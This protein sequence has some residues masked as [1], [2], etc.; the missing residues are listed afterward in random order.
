MPEPIPMPIARGFAGWLV[1]AAALAALM[2]GFVFSLH[3][4][5]RQFEIALLAERQAGLIA[6]L[7][8][9]P[10]SQFPPRL[11]EYRALVAQ[12]SALGSPAHSDELARINRLPTMVD[13]ARREALLATMMAGERAEVAAARAALDH[14]RNRMLLLGGMLTLLALVS[15]GTGLWRL[16]WA[17]RALEREV[18]ARSAQLQ[19][20]DRSRRLFFAKASHELRTPVAAMRSLAEV[21]LSAGGDQAAALHDVVAQAQF[22]SHRIDEMLSLASAQEGRPVLAPAPY[23][24]REIVAGALSAAGPF[25]R[26]VEVELVYDPP[27][28]SVHVRADGRWLGQALLAIIDNGLKISDPGAALEITLIR[29]HAYAI[30]SIADHGPGMGE[31]DLPLIFEAY[32]Q[33]EEGRHRGG[34]GLGLALARWVADQHGGTIRAENRATGGARIVLMLPL[35]EA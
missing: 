34:T 25:A 19:A 10:L 31:A 4:A 23:D 14:S 12:E 33:S 3:S 18:A 11:A 20:V 7:S 24:L 8:G 15:A 5:A 29:D 26:L 35:E 22:L 13:T 1:M 21:T 17:N 27:A 30:L 2:A 28:D 16:V 6:G 9:Q 32:Y